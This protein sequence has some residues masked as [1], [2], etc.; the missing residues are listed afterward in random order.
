[1]QIKADEI[2]FDWDEG[3]LDKSRRKHGVTPEEAESVFLD[4]NSLVFPD[5]PHSE[6]E[7]RLIVVGK[8]D[9]NRNLFIVFTLRREKVRIISARRMHKKEVEKY[10][11]IKKNTKI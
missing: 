6:T 4:E 2:G 3:N 1:M 8:S 9:K 7:A 5:K 10:G 11:K